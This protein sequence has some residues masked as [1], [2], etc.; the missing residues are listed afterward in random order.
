MKDATTFSAS[1][2]LALKEGSARTIFEG[3]PD[4]IR[5]L[6]RKLVRQWH[7]D[8][9]ADPQASDVFVRLKALYGHALAL[10][11][12]KTAVL[13]DTSIWVEEVVDHQGHRFRL[14]AQ[15]QEPFELGT[16]LRGKATS[17][18]YTHL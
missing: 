10:A 14:N 5:E 6:Y 1:D 13:N 3:S 9:N 16:F 4:Q 12:G 7:P 17:V 8:R 2:W 11:G 18:S 15:A